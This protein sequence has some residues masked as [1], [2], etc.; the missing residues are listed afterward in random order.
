[1]SAKLPPLPPLTLGGVVLGAAVVQQSRWKARQLLRCRETCVIA[2]RNITAACWHGC[3]FGVDCSLSCAAPMAMLLATGLMD[4]R[5][6]VVI[7]SA[8]T[9]E[10]VAP[11]G[12]RIARATGALA[13]AAGLI[14]CLRALGVALA[15]AA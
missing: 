13:V 6:M 2:P 15:P 1:M 14:M 12:A 7:T 3:R 4:V 8:I 11:D 10:R 9:V 5:V